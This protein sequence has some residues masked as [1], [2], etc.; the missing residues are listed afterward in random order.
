MVFGCTTRSQLGVTFIWELFLSFFLGGCKPLEA[1]SRLS[2]DGQCSK[3]KDA[4]MQMWVWPRSR[5]TLTAGARALGLFGKSGPAI[6]ESSAIL[7]S[8]GLFRQMQSTRRNLEGSQFFFLV[9]NRNS[10]CLLEVSVVL[11]GG[12][13]SLFNDHDS[14]RGNL[15]CCCKLFPCI[16]HSISHD[17]G[18]RETWD[19]CT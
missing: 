14:Y 6:G 18:S 2:N 4:E 1:Q 12:V 16:R 7:I 13:R 5:W 17:A 9:I 19:I 15:R 11:E 8:P 10:F 3:A